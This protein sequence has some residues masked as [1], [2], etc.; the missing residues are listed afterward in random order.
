MQTTLQETYSLTGMYP[1]SVVAR[2][3][4]QAVSTVL[5]K[6]ISGSRFTAYQQRHLVS[7]Q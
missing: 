6:L 2:Q 3:N 7:G 4:L 5:I 1:I